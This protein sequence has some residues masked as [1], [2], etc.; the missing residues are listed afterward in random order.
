[1]SKIFLKS[2][3]TGDLIAVPVD[4]IEGVSSRPRGGSVV[5]RRG[6]DNLLVTETVEQVQDRIDAVRLPFVHKNT[7]QQS[8]QVVT[9]TQVVPVPVYRPKTMTEDIL[10]TAAGVGLGVFGGELLGDL[11]DSI[12]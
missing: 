2:A 3:I 1:M 12:F 8:T 11:F 9:K 5:K 10:T 6:R 4:S 7:V